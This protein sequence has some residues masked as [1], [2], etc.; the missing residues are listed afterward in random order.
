[1]GYG[2]PRLPS[3]HSDYLRA[4]WEQDSALVISRTKALH[5]RLDEL[6]NE[7]NIAVRSVLN[8]K[9]GED[10]VRAVLDNIDKEINEVNKELESFNQ[11]EQDFIE[12]VKFSIDFIEN[13][14]TKFWELDAE[15]IAM[16]KQLL[17]PDG[18]SVSRDK[19]V[20]TP[21]I[22]DIYRLVHKQK[23]PAVADISYMA[24]VSGCASEK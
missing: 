8:A 21:K 20:H 22:S 17:F 3:S 24:G 10:D 5:K 2:R 12:F 19:K 14:R 6:K 1:M 9:F 16:C 15:N 23:I 11:I 13:L 4:V 7:R 18:F